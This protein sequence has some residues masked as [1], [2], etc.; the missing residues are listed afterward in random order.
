MT[1]PQIKGLM[2]PFEGILIF[3]NSLKFQMDKL[4]MLL[5]VQY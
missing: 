4:K 5:I 2:S 1:Y 3:Y